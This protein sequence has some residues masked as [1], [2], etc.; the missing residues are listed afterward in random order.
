MPALLWCVLNTRSSAEMLKNT[1][2]K[3]TTAAGKDLFVPHN[4]DNPQ[5]KTFIAWWPE[6]DNFPINHAASLN[7]ELLCIL[8][9]G[10]SHM[11][12]K[13]HTQT[14][15]STI[16][17]LCSLY[18]NSSCHCLWVCPLSFWFSLSTYKHNIHGRAQISLAHIWNNQ[19]KD[20]PYLIFGRYKHCYKIFLLQYLV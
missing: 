15:I 7:L 8:D 2:R 13:N 17:R 20:C 1:W 3:E 12:N 9:V 18:I 16:D 6:A 4:R 5:R 19:R 14:L 11:T 10:C